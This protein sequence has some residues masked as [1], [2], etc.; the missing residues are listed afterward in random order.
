MQSW[1]EQEQANNIMPTAC[2]WVCPADQ[3]AAA[4]ERAI[5]YK[6]IRSIIN[7]DVIHQIELERIQMHVW[8]VSGVSRRIFFPQTIILYRLSSQQLQ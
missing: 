5:H 7:K 6:I 4:S 2:V 8:T 3:Q 1:E